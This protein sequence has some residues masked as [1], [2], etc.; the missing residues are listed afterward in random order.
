MKDRAL[1]K[2]L[3]EKFERW[4]FAS[5]EEK[6]MCEKSFMT[7][8]QEE[9]QASLKTAKNLRAHFENLQ[10]EP[11]KQPEKPKFKVNRFV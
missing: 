7:P 2:S 9:L 5:E 3:R 10:K 11:P 4:E 6:Q 8:E 1:G